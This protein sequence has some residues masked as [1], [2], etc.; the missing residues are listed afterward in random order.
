MTLHTLFDRSAAIGFSYN[1]LD[2]V[3][4]Q[5]EDANFIAE[6]LAHSSSRFLAFA[7][8]TPLLRLKDGAHDALFDREGIE[9]F[10]DSRQ[11]I[12]LGLQSDG[13]AVFAWS[14]DKALT[15]ELAWRSDMEAVDLRSLAMRGLVPP[16]I[17]GELGTAK[18]VL[19][20]HQ[21]HRFCANCGTQTEPTAGGWRRDCSCCNAQ[22]FPRVD[23][24][25]IMLAID[26]DRCLMG[27]QTRFPEKMYSA[28]AGFLE[29]GETIEDAVRR[30]L[31]EESG[32]ACSH[33]SYFASQPWPFPSSL[34]IGC[35]A[36]AIGNDIKV[37]IKELED[38]RWF[39]R[40][41]VIA[42]L[43]ESHPEGFSSPKPLAIAYHLLK[44]FADKGSA[45]VA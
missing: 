16:H 13:G 21:R 29:P 34:M 19:D 7:G 40:A 5:R 18:E 42:M 28:L 4:G 35:F 27:R 38:A 41:E 24:V 2:R 10:K 8:D 44:E 25:V 22:H 26:G 9:S 20:W 39:T 3:S 14:F 36:R 17:L 33:V 12:F 6:K 43:A 23:P 37:D 15:D 32:I 11:S 30:E 31:M 1:P 45:V